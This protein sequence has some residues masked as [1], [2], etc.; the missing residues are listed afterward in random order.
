MASSDNIGR[1]ASNVYTV[2]AIVGTVCLLTA[3]IITWKA[4]V[5]LTEGH[6]DAASAVDG[7]FHL[8]DR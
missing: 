8:I 1:P 5:E 4:N 2:L 3:V 6:A 7:A